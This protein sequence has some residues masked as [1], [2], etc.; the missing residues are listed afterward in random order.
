MSENTSRQREVPELVYLLEAGASRA[1]VI[2]YTMKILEW[3]MITV[4]QTPRQTHAQT[5]ALVNA[6]ARLVAGRQELLNEVGLGYPTEPVE[7]RVTAEPEA[8]GQGD[9]P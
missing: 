1:Q 7:A 3:A 4:A 6:T 9:R 2:N 8:G 5:D